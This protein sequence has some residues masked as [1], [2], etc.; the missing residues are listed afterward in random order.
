MDMLE[1]ILPRE[2]L[3][4]IKLGGSLITE[5][6]S[7]QTARLA[8]MRRLS[9]E[10]ASARSQRP[11]LHILLG[12]GSGSFGHVPAQKY[13]TRQGVHSGAEWLGFLEVWQAAAQLNRLV[14]DALTASGLPAISLPPSASIIARDGQVVSWDLE[15]IQSA[16]KV[17]LIPVVFGDVIFDQKKGGTI[18]STEDLFAHLAPLLMPGRIILAGIE[19]GVWKDFPV[20]SEIIQ[21]ITPANMAGIYSALSGSIATDV[22]GGMA[23]KVQQSSGPGSK[24]SRFDRRN[25]IR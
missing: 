22:T 9:K 18:L 19:P 20:K 25:P 2:E 14:Q 15:P 16:L 21:E 23:S 8:T 3:V 6:E 5:K 7:P 1:P 4:F 13:G 10:I 24:G 12:H 17:G 11:T